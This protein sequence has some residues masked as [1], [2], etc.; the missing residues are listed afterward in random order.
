MKH[1]SLPSLVLLCGC[2]VG[3][4]AL[5]SS[6][7]AQGFYFNANAGVALADDVRLKEFLTPTPGVDIEFDPGAR[8]SVSGGYNIND[9]LSV[10]LE[11][12]FMVNEVDKVDGTGNFD[13][14]LGHVPFMGNVTLRYDK[15]DCNWVPYVGA[16]A[17]GDASVLSLDHVRGPNGAVVDG[18]DTTAVFAWQLFA[19]LRYKFHPNMSIGGG[20]KFYS[21]S[22]ASWEVSRSSGD[23]EI[24]TA[25]V[26]SIGVDFT[27]K[28]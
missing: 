9:F 21:A 4:S 23:I 6:G 16:A 8:L 5:A 14:S 28:F 26:H 3:L 11:T 2:A 15:P 12:G 20:Y 7:Q 10:G 27:L 25:R 18:D 19:G 17:G 22:S 1:S 13:A 24:G